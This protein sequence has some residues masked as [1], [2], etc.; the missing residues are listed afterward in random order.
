MFDRYQ[1]TTQ[2][3]S[4]I[5]GK[6]YLSTTLYPDI[7]EREDDLFIKVS[8]TDRLD[9]LAYRYY[10]DISLWWV[11]VKANLLSGD[12][13]FIE[14]GSTIRIPTNIIEIIEAHRSLN[15]NR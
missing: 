13:Y 2:R 8:P 11:I 14:P 5:T 7:A 9:I 3:T 10:K 6:R 15:I 4:D 12:S 1:Y